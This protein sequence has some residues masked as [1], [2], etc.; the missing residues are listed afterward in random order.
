M[1]TKTRY[2]D[3]C[4]HFD[5]ALLDAGEGWPCAEGHAPRFYRAQE[6]TLGGKW[7]GWKRRCE[8]F[9]EKRDDHPANP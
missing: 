4:D 7:G 6:I 9:K 3:E 5:A 2:C 1:T 8:D